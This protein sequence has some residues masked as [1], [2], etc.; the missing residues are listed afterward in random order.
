MTIIFLLAI[1]AFMTYLLWDL[2]ANRGIP[3]FA[4]VAASAAALFDVGYAWFMGLF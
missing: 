4:A 2:T 1:I 3:I